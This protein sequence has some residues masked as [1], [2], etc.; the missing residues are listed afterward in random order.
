MSPAQAPRNRKL[1]ASPNPPHELASDKEMIA[2]PPSV[3]AVA[4]VEKPTTETHQPGDDDADPGTGM[5][6][7]S[8]RPKTPRPGN[9]SRSR[10]LRPQKPSKLAENAV[11]VADYL[12]RYY[13]PITGR[14]PSRDPIGE[15]GGVNLYGFVRNDGMNQWDILGL[16]DY[17][18]NEQ[19]GNIPRMYEPSLESIAQA[20]KYADAIKSAL[21]G[22]CIE[23]ATN[24]HE[25]ID[26]LFDMVKNRK[27]KLQEG[28]DNRYKSFWRTLTTDGTNDSTLHELVHAY[29]DVNT[30]LDDDYLYNAA[31]D[32]VNEGMAYEI[33]GVFH[34]LSYLANLERRV[35][36]K[37]GVS[38]DN[39]R[40]SLQK[41]L[42]P[43]SMLNRE[44][45]LNDGA[46]SKFLTN[47]DDYKNLVKHL[48]L[49]IDCKK[50]VECMS[51]LKKDCCENEFDAEKICPEWMK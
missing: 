26:K 3:T 11:H 37:I 10:S 43:S 18:D 36:S 29:V 31:D 5:P 22:T 2:T 17:Y 45:I 8:P 15:S 27:V 16:Q 32:R 50:L 33:E 46:T 35:N 47:E 4:V 39:F 20:K 38:C 49:K 30:N 24:I 40:E 1:S 6:A 13:D 9:A 42:N 14:W 44:G 41:N 25:V 48:G 51:G 7:T 12:Y 21:K 28:I 34:Y 23:K 19:G